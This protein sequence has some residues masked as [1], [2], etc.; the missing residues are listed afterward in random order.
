MEK[1]VNMTN[2]KSEMLQAYNE[3]M[4]K[5]KKQSED[6]KTVQQRSKKEETVKL[7]SDLSVETISKNIGTLK[8]NL[9]DPLNNLE[10]QIIE[11]FK[12]FER[13]REA[14]KVEKENLE[15]LYKITTEAHSL[16]ALIAA[17][18][19]QKE[20][21]EE[22]MEQK[23]K[24][25]KAEEEQRNREQ[26]REEEEYKYNLKINRKKEQDL[27][28]EKK[29][30]LEKGLEERKQAFEKEMSQREEAVKQAEAELAE[31][32]NKAEAFP[33]ILEAEIKK[34][35]EETEKYLKQ[36]FSFEKQLTDNKT[37][38]DLQLN[39]QTIETL[40]AKIKDQEALIKQLTDKVNTSE[41][42]V[43]QIALKAL[44]SSGKERIITVDKGKE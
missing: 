40:K 27:Y 21:F 7:V 38:G 3:L 4:G 10:E 44:E 8:A 29:Q 23:R 2:T 15:E 41:T 22:E 17:Q 9:A 11:A 12:E 18:K 37:K 39:D 13:I 42:S 28:E 24:G 36:Q 16:A 6:A 43:K 31:L 32:R 14:V 25:L 35:K 33:K 30:K 19:K 26:K 20:S 5:L 1:K 34:A